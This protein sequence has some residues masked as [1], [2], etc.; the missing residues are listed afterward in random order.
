M[1]NKL[2]NPARE[3]Y[4]VALRIENPTFNKIE[5]SMTDFQVSIDEFSFVLSPTNT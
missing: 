1:V 5:G 3:I 2:R 4:R